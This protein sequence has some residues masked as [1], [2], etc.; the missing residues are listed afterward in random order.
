M[1]DATILSRREGLMTADMNG[2]AVMM[3]IMTGKYYNLGQIGGRIW[4]I[5]E[6]PMTVAA[7][8]KKLTDEYDVSAAQCRSDILPFLDTLLERGLLLE[9]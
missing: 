2:S 4:E 7:L 9:A 8:V 6:E 3:D 1:T 5:L